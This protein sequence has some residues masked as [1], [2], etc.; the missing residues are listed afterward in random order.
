MF[1]IDR[2]EDRWAVIE[3]GRETFNLP[4][5]LIPQ[6]A[7]EGDVIVIS[8][9]VDTKATEDLKKDVRALAGNLFKD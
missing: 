6:G 9:T 3:H 5:E 8:V 2:L 4:R 7:M 1:I